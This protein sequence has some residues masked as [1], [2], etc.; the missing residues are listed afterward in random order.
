MSAPVPEPDDP[1]PIDPVEAPPIDPSSYE[2]PNA[3]DSS[4]EGPWGSGSAAPERSSDTKP[5]RGPG[6]SRSLHQRQERHLYQ[7]L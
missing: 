5:R 3:R 1:T 2:N 6:R 7:T 4:K